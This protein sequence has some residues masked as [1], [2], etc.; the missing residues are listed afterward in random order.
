MVSP[1]HLQH[2]NRDAQSNTSALINQIITEL[3]VPK[4]KFE[5]S[6]RLVN[7]NETLQ[8]LKEIECQIVNINRQMQPL[9]V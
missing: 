3:N 4:A 5:H 8:L 7:T 6:N 9:P 2:Q 1:Y